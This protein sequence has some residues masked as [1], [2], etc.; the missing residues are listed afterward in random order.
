MTSNRNT[1]IPGPEESARLRTTL[2]ALLRHLRTEAGVSTRALASRSAVARSTITR[3]EAGQRRPRPAMLAALAHGLDPA[4]AAE[5]TEHL[6]AA[7]ADSLRPDTEGG[8]RRLSRRRRRREREVDRRVDQMRLQAGA[9]VLRSRRMTMAA[10]RLLSPHAAWEEVDLAGCLHEQAVL[11]QEEAV[12]L[13]DAALAPRHPLADPV[14][15]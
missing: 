11:L 15:P 3:L 9:L 1:G 7:A 4:R 2:G 12:R 13:D 14:H 6:A 5:L 10:L 8:T